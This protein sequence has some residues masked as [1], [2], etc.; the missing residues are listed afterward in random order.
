MAP[1][2]QWNCRGVR[3]NREELDILIQSKNP[4]AICLQ[5]TKL[6]SK[7]SLSV[8][9]YSCFLKNLTS[10]VAHGG[11]MI[12]VSNSTPHSEITLVTELQAVAVRI[13]SHRPI[14]LYSLYLPPNLPIN[15][16]Y[17]ENLVN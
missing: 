2:I 15:L 1:I 9:N 14:S 17:L 4:M 3:P 13:T 10:E 5:E 12:L 8:K 6:N 11:V 16:R 7:N